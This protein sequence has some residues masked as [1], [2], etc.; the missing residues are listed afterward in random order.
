V[1]ELASLIGQSISSW[2]Q[3][4]LEPQ[5]FDTDDPDQISAQIDSFC[6]HHLRCDVADGL[7]YTP[8]SAAS[9]EWY[10]PTS[11]KR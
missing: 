6:R 3:A 10:S 5:V 11:A 2:G 4:V 9:S 7:F 8:R 1:T